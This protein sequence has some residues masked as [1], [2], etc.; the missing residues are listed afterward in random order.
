MTCEESLNSFLGPPDP[1][2]YYTIRQ[3]ILSPYYLP[4]PLCFR[5]E[6]GEGGGDKK[7][8]ISPPL[9]TGLWLDIAAEPYSFAIESAMF[10]AWGEF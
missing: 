10:A 3:N 6:E 2:Y 9:A 7:V 4:P 5:S 1:R 8:E